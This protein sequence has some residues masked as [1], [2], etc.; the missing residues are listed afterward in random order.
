MEIEKTGENTGDSRSS[1][2]A[3]GTN[4]SPKGPETKVQVALRVRPQISK[5]LLNKEQPCVQSFPMTGQVY[6]SFFLFHFIIHSL[7]IASDGGTC[8]FCILRG[9][10]KKDMIKLEGI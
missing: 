3:N 10:Y 7:L 2:D 9:I 6:L 1:F 8:F 5:E 4:K